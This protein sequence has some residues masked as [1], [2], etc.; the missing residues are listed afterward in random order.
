MQQGCWQINSSFP[1]SAVGKESDFDILNMLAAIPVPSYVFDMETRRFL[2]ANPAFEDLLGYSNEELQQMTVNELRPK[3]N[4]ALLE[5]ALKAQ[6]PE[7]AVEWR[8]VS[9]SGDLLHVSIKYRNSEFLIGGRLH[10]TRLVV[11]T[12]WDRAPTRRARALFE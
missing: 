7:G 2:A 6:P 8:Y 5:R 9:K 1:S 10:H 11:V 12:S 4:V 3:D